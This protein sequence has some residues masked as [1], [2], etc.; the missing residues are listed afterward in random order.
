[1]FWLPERRHSAH[2]GREIQERY[3]TAIALWDASHNRDSHGFLPEQHERWL[4]YIAPIK[5]EIN[6]ERAAFWKW[7]VEHGR[8]KP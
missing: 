6:V 7:L 2:A 5:G 8:V 4:Q 3:A 1:M